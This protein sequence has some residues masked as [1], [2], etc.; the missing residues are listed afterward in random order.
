MEELKFAVSDQGFR[1]NKV[2][3]SDIKY[4]FLEKAQAKVRG[5]RVQLM[6]RLFV[7]PDLTKE[8]LK[9]NRGNLVSLDGRMVELRFDPDDVEAGGGIWAIDPR[10]KKSIYLTQVVAIDPT[11][12]ESAKKAIERKRANMKPVRELFKSISS[13]ELPGPV[14]SDPERYQG[15]IESASVTA[16][17]QRSIGS[18]LVTTALE[19][20][21]FEAEVASRISSEPVAKPRLKTAYRSHRDRYEAVLLSIMSSEHVSPD[22]LAF[23]SQYESSMSEADLQYWETFIRYHKGEAR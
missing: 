20:E 21:D 8:M 15:L 22:D 4:I 5:D 16:T 19:D 13:I 11:N 2:D 3:E 17:S 1:I 10:D 9:D 14:L 12:D 23:K 7:G 6:D 18:D